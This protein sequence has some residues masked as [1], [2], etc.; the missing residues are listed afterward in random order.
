MKKKTY[1]DWPTH[2][3]LT[4]KNMPNVTLTI[5]KKIDIIANDPP[6]TVVLDVSDANEVLKQFMLKGKGDEQSK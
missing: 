5:G 6:D 3:T 1:A 2:Y 4:I